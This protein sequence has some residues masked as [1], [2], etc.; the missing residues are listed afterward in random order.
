MGALASFIPLIILLILLLSIVSLI[1]LSPFHISARLQTYKLL[2]TYLAVLLVG[3]VV[4]SFL[5]VGRE[6][7]SELI[8]KQEVEDKAVLNDQL[9]FL[10]ID[11]N[12]QEAKDIAYKVEQTS[13]PIQKNQ[14]IVN[15]LTTDDE[16]IKATIVLEHTGQ[17]TDSIEV[18]QYQGY[19]TYGRI[20]ISDK[21]DFYQI[22]MLQED[23][24][25]RAPVEKRKEVALT[26]Q[27]FATYQFTGKE[28]F[29]E[30]GLSLI[31]RGNIYI[32]VPIG[33]DV[34]GEVIE[35]KE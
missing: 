25:I 35:V 12:W 10:L 23:L 3:T 5:S 20:D 27:S 7:E 21:T 1:R 31:G 28:M 19:T 16:I 6:F 11:G 32:R 2:M 14:L 4:F 15:A 34:T 17:L 30:D 22:E 33:V 24:Q 26:N 18:I 13:F 9:Y 29:V 8:N